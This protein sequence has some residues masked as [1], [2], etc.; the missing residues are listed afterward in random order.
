MNTAKKAAFVLA[1]AGLAAG[2]AAGSAFATGGP[3][4]H[5]QAVSS[6]GVGSGNLVQAPVDVPVNATGNSVN[7][8]GLLN[9]AFGNHAVNH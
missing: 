2:A 5:G 4:A 6:P 8:V 1:T 3:Q 9:A 7:V